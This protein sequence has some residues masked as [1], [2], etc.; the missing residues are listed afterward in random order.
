MD[1][2]DDIGMDARM[3]ARIV[4]SYGLS[5][6]DVAVILRE[7][8]DM[9]P[10]SIFGNDVLTPLEAL[11][12]YLRENRGMRFAQIAPIAGRDQRNIAATYHRA[13]EK[14]PELLL[15]LPVRH[16]FPLKLL[17]DRRLSVFEHVVAHL[18]RQGLTLSEIAAIT[19]RD[20]RTI[21]TLAHRAKM[22]LR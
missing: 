11:V 14:E 6:E 19:R 22:K 16:Y 13:K 10:V 2:R 5:P 17:Q 12:K 3:L 20:Q 7:R 9:V 18:Q 4:R 1:K 15:E 21:W 8:E